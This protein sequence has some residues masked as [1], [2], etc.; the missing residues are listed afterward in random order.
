MLPKARFELVAENQTDPSQTI[1]RETHHLFCSSAWDWGFTQFLALECLDDPAKGFVVGDRLVLKVRMSVDRS[2][3]CVA[4]SRAETGFAGIK[5]AGA[6]CGLN[7][8]IQIL[9]HLPRFR[10]LVYNLQTNLHSGNL[11]QNA[12]F[13][14][15]RLFFQLQYS[16]SSASTASVRK[17]LG[18]AVYDGLMSLEVQDIFSRLHNLLEQEEMAVENG[19]LGQL[20][21]GHYST[22]V[23]CI[24]GGAKTE[25]RQAFMGIDL[26][27]EG[28][29]G[30]YAS[31]DKFCEVEMLEGANKYHAEGY[32]WVDARKCIRFDSLPAVLQLNLK[33][34]TYDSK[35]GMDI[36]V[37]SHYQFYQE[38]NMDVGERKYLTSN[39][40]GGC[41]YKLHSVVVRS[42]EPQ[43]G[44]CS[45]FIRPVG[46]KWLK[47]DDE[48][49]EEVLSDNAIKDQYGGRD[50][51]QGVNNY[52]LPS[53]KGGR[54]TACA[55]VYVRESDWDS[56]MCVAGK[57]DLPDEV[58]RHLEIQ[59][60]F[61]VPSDQQR[62]WLCAPR[63]G[64][65]PRPIC[66][67]RSGTDSG[68]S[69]N[70][71]S[72]TDPG[73]D[74]PTFAE[75]L[76]SVQ[77]RPDSWGAKPPS[78]VLLYLETWEPPAEKAA[79]TDSKKRRGL[80][81]LLPGARGGSMVR[82]IAANM[83]YKHGGSMV[84]FK[85]YD[86]VNESLTYV[87]RRFV[88]NEEVLGDVFDEVGRAAGLQGEVTG[89]KEAAHEPVLM[90]VKLNRRFS[91][92]EVR[93][94]HGDI[95]CLE[96]PLKGAQSSDWPHLRCPTARDYLLRIH[97]AV[98]GPTL[99]SPSALDA[100][101]WF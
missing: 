27:V 16:C 42:D 87:Q 40:T 33:R 32:G 81:H 67:L 34:S 47:F 54:S 65:A 41:V 25:R 75:V 62:L 60:D 97:R 95:V 99:P 85:A 69:A 3:W 93:L 84:F 29:D 10:K 53:S 17:L 70:T 82:L 56:V 73:T 90:G 48:V 30:V 28:C 11:D 35:K 100:L 52:G 1:S 89:W 38:L 36:K 76:D 77:P 83:V 45:V 79:K 44:H 15:Q 98:Q 26:E 19:G 86:P 37:S 22:H 9:F 101:G 63:D 74:G 4:A 61:G 24:S 96:S 58:R 91:C 43:G 59:T 8:A 21:L 72:S 68:T 71:Y 6:T 23:E 50:T 39:V 46:D 20:F 13:V 7:A 51:S 78:T 18:L 14:L 88:A 66:P 55:L 5:N 57:D 49:V 92:R 12:G 64:S 80:R 94:V 31:L 2:R